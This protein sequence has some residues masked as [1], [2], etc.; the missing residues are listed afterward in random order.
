MSDCDGGVL[1]HS[2]FPLLLYQ[3][4]YLESAV[5]HSPW[6]HAQWQVQLSLHMRTDAICLNPR[7]QTYS[8]AWLHLRLIQ[9]ISVETINRTRYKIM[10]QPRTL[11]L[12]KR[13]QSRSR[14][15]QPKRY[16][17]EQK[18]QVHMNHRQPK[19]TSTSSGLPRPAIYLQRLSLH[20]S[21]RVK[22][23]E[24]RLH[25]ALCTRTPIQLLE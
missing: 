18:Q 8:P 12:S 4:I 2:V 24:T 14:I 22:T 17:P 19:Q 21:R 25:T 23:G 6:L 10:A 16:Q 20:R 11:H 3:S 5:G 15:N 9:F 13:R 1:D 7:Y